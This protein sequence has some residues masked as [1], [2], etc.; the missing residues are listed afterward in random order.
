MSSKILLLLQ[1][2]QGDIDQNKHLNSGFLISTCL[3]SVMKEIGRV[4]SAE[5]FSCVY[6]EVSKILLLMELSQ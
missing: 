2:S 4:N 6:R 5:T 3:D 1:L